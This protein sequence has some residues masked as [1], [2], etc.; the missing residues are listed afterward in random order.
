MS[1]PNP[2]RKAR[3][4]ERRARYGVVDGDP[5]CQNCGFYLSQHVK[6][7]NAGEGKRLQCLFAPTVFTP[8]RK[9][10]R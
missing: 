3:L 9:E 6:V 4:A 2:D 10:M 1:K 5:F 8:K 7:R